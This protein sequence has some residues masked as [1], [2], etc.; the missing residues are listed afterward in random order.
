MMARKRDQ[1]FWSWSYRLWLAAMWVLG[2][3]LAPILKEQL[4]TFN[5]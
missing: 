4:Y 3:K 2:T 5:H 1:I